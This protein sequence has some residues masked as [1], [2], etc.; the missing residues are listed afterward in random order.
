MSNTR[1][2]ILG[3]LAKA[4]ITDKSVDDVISDFN[5]SDSLAQ[6]VYGAEDVEASVLAHITD[7]L[8]LQGVTGLVAPAAQD[9]TSTVKAGAGAAMPA[10]VTDAQRTAIVAISQST[11]AERQN[12]SNKAHL[13]ASLA[14]KPYPGEYMSNIGK[15]PVKGDLAKFREGI[16]A[17]YQPNGEVANL[18]AKKD[19][20]FIPTNDQLSVLK[21][22]YPTRPGAKKPATSKA[23]TQKVVADPA[24]VGFDNDAAYSNI[25]RQ[26]SSGDG[27]FEVMVA[28]KE[29]TGI[30]AAKIKGWRWATKG[31]AVNRPS[32]EAGS[33]VMTEVL[34]NKKQLIGFLVAQTLG[35]LTPAT[36]EGLSAKLHLIT[37]KATE[38]AGQS[39][40]AKK[41]TL[42]V[43]GDSIATHPDVRFIKKVGNGQGKMVCRSKD[44][45]FAVRI[46]KEGKWSVRKQRVPLQWAQAPVFETKQEYIDLF[47]VNADG[48]TKRITAGDLKVMQEATTAFVAQVM[49]EGNA[50]EYN[51][52]GLLNEVEE[53]INKSAV[54]AAKSLSI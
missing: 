51:L 15:L 49:N 34:M 12:M 19:T 36:P 35:Y 3:Y 37:P 39:A 11:Y 2:E 24:W 6:F 31:Y 50:G 30:G 25:L 16:E 48:T 8:A 42:R 22:L 10:A 21:G 23:G 7:Y 40:T 13:V 47:P 9:P 26:L 45:Y 44:F 38:E 46:D 1:E 53:R 17:Q 20:W 4:G 29:D 18:I 41:P 5:A 43:R 27:T 14:E 54:A 52:Q 32:A 33:D 28:P